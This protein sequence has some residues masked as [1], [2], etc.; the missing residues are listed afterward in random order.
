MSIDPDSLVADGII[1]K[2]LAAAIVKPEYF[3]VGYRVLELDSANDEAWHKI[4]RT[5]KTGRT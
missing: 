4:W 2:N 3:D 5:F 1:P